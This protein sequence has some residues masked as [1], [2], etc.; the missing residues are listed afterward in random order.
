MGQVPPSAILVTADMGGLYPSIPHDS[1]VKAIYEKLQEREVK[2][3]PLAD[4]VNM[5]EFV[6]KKY[7]EFDSNGRKQISGTATGTKFAP[8]YT[9][10]I[11]DKAES[12]F[13]QSEEY[14]PWVC[15]RYKDY[16]FFHLD[17]K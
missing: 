7:F 15:L 12:D 17:R 5:A 13:L 1:G 2:Q 10:I 16:F 6:L 14:K 4:L 8:P 9:C 3:I 11:M